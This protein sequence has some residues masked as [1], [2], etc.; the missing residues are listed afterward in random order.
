MPVYDGQ[1]NA[2]DRLV[3]PWYIAGWTAQNA[4]A[5][6]IEIVPGLLT[7]DGFPAGLVYAEV[8]GSYFD[9]D[10][11]AL[12]GFLTLMMSDNVTITAASRTF[13]MPARLAGQD[14][15]QTGF[16][17]ANWGSGVI[18]LGHGHLGV[19][20]LCTDNAGLTTDSGQPLTY[21]VT[22]HFLGGRVYQ[23]SVPSATVSPVDI[24]SLIVSGTVQPYSYDP[25]NPMGNWL[26]PMSKPNTVA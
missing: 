26:I 6:S 24:N 13:R 8:T 3:Q 23:I 22:E 17:R 21:W 16:G 1:N 25:V 19:S 12:G 11:S 7:P 5:D 4:A 9:M 15:T 20:L 10:G 14:S 18:Y 2:D